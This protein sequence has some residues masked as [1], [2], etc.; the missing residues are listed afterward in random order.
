VGLG[1]PS[2]E[3]FRQSYEDAN[4]IVRSPG[5][6]AIAVQA[7]YDVVRTCYDGGDFNLLRNSYSGTEVTTSKGE[8]TV[9]QM[10][11]D[12]NALLGE[13]KKKPIEGCGAKKVF[14]SSD[15]TGTGQWTK[16]D[17]SRPDPDE[18]IPVPC[19][20]VVPSPASGELASM[21]EVV[22]KACPDATDFAYP[23]DWMNSKN[24]L[25][26]VT[27]REANVICF[28]KGK[29]TDWNFYSNSKARR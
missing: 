4:N 29:R 13:L 16:P 17:W 22:K 8:K 28:F 14:F 24:Q 5:S 2:T 10:S 25:D 7:A 19:D 26:V 21:E 11:Q 15:V 9:K 20:K 27:H 12:C 1:G 18:Y 6:D 23:D 3:K